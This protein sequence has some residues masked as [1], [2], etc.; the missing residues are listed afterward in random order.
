[1]GQAQATYE[2]ARERW[3]HYLDELSKALL[4][5]P[6][7]I[8]IIGDPTHPIVQ[9]SHLALL[10]LTYDRHDDAIEI[11][12][13]RGGPHLPG[14]LRHLIEHPARVCLDSHWMQAPITIAIDGSDNVRTVVAIGH[15][16]QIT[17]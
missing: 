17:G 5:E 8:E 13:A 9:A 11:S 4:H 3:P 1:M 2:L 12:V 7:S 10:A 15:E 14:V 16:P 6:V